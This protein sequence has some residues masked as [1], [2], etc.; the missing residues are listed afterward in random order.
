MMDPVA[1]G[2]AACRRAGIVVVPPEGWGAAAN[3]AAMSRRPVPEHGGQGFVH[4][5]GPATSSAAARGVPS[6]I[7]A[8]LRSAERYHLSKKWAGLAYDVASGNDGALYLIRGDARSAA[9]SG[10]VD[11]DGIPNNVEGDAMLFVIG[12]GQEPSPAALRTATIFWRGHR[13]PDRLTPHRDARGTTTTCPGATLSRWA[14][15]FRMETDTMDADL[16]ILYHPTVG[17]PDATAA[18]AV[19][20]LRPDLTIAPVCNAAGAAS[21]LAAGIRTVAVGR[22]G[23]M[24]AGDEDLA[25]ADRIGTADQLI[26]LVRAL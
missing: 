9:T 17:V 11:M 5:V 26:E 8:A 22:A 24:L 13:G 20:S 6:A 14:R 18:L 12:S 21:A 7:A 15:E 19:A 1:R 25:G 3:Y 4:W 10:D 16:V 2:V 23:D